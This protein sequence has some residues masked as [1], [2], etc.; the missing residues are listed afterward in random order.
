MKIFLD[1]ANI[2][3]INKA[4]QWGIIDGVTTN[5]TLIAKE[6]GDVRK[7]YKDLL[8]MICT[9]VLGPVSAEV[10][11]EETEGM[12]VEAEDLAKINKN[13][14]IKVPITED[15]ITTIKTLSIAGIKTNAT[16]VFSANQALLAAK[17]GATYISPF[18]GRIDD[19]G[20]DGMKVVE[21][22]LTI[23]KNYKFKSQVI[24][25]SVRSPKT[26]KDG[27]LLGAHV[28]TVPF[29]ILERM[30]KHSLTDKGIKRF[31]EDWKKFSK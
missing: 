20:E 30:F 4:C 22:I 28:A 13:I 31:N 21:E 5:P 8:L 7:N 19:E 24:V 9:M 23:L 16:L 26:V 27:A 18:V 29:E 6:G 15:G 17:A 1:T 3:K 10:T 25:S 14:V 2:E 12:L 11:A